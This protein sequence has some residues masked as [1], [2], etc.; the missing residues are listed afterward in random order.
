VGDEGYIDCKTLS[1]KKSGTPL[2]GDFDMNQRRSSGKFC[3]SSRGKT[4]GASVI[5]INWA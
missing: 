3:A 1:L 2:F 4:G 5:R